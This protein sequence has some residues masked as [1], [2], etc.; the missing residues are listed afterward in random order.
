MKR[1]RVFRYGRRGGCHAVRLDSGLMFTVCDGRKFG[2]GVFW[3]PLTFWG[4]KGRTPFTD[5]QGHG[6]AIA[7]P[8]PCV[9]PRDFEKCAELMRAEGLR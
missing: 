3:R 9:S 8:P 2:N 6:P 5:G 1:A 4:M 7:G